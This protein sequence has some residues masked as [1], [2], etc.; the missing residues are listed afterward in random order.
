MG[1]FGKDASAPV[2][3]RFLRRQPQAAGYADFADFEFWR[4]EIDS[5]HFIEGFGRIVT[6]PGTAMGVAFEDAA[7]FSIAEATHSPAL[8][9]RWP[10]LTGFDSE[11]VDLLIGA[12]PGR[13]TFDHAAPNF[14][15][16]QAAAAKCL[17]TMPPT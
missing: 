10:A 17:G 5:A 9:Q 7:D 4:M 1:R 15:M 11:G 12:Q 16:A 13:L 8:R 14:E 3:S 6:L 2:R